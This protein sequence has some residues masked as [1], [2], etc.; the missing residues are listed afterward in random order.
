[1]DEFK[2]ALGHAS[3]VSS[4]P[5]LVHLVDA[6]RAVETAGAHDPVL[7]TYLAKLGGFISKSNFALDARLAEEFSQTLGEAHFYCMCLDKRVRL[8]RVPEEANLKTPDFRYEVDGQELFFEVKTPSVV[9]GTR[10]LSNALQSNLDAKINLEQQLRSGKKIAMAESEAQPYGE[11]PCRDG[12]VRGVIAVLL[13]KA[14]Q[15][16][17]AGQ[18]GKPNTFL[19]LNLSVIPPFRTEG[20]VLRPAYCD[21][22][23]FAKAVSGELW[24]LAF[25]RPGMLVHGIPEFEG[26]PC[27]EGT[28]DKEG[29]LVEHEN[30]AGILFMI[31]PWRYPAELWALLRF[32]EFWK[33]VDTDSPVPAT[34]RTL[35]GNQ[36]NDDL[37]SN[38]WQ[39]NVERR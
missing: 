36:W 9:G 1:V 27:I 38:G 15:N 29:L 20:K 13:E 23:M 30:I 33:W 31:H 16:I 25:C 28:I 11:K 32:V 21:D 26:K 14:R 7:T 24:M 18:F 35:A 17:K 19:V 12:T 37:D 34:V 2:A 8:E 4:N 3:D 10:G 39:L 5:Y 6:L 22:Y